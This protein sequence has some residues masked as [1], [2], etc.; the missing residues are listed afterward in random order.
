ML[1]F[2]DDNLTF[3]LKYYSPDRLDTLSAVRRF[4]ES[5]GMEEHPSRRWST[6]LAAM[7]GTAA[8]AFAGYRLVNDRKAVETSE[9][10]AVME[11]TTAPDGKEW[12]F[13]YTDIP[14][15]DILAELSEYYGCTLSTEAEG[16]RLTASFHDD[17]IDVIIPLIEA[18][19]GIEIEVKE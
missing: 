7:L 2:N 17:G 10:Q 13:V 15:E 16:R 19:L 3:V 14:L 4:K 11:Q 1:N 12:R 9:E 8:V 18:A 5:V 6:S